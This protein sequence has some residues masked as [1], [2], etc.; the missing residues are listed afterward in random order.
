VYRASD[1]TLTALTYGRGI[2]VTIVPVNGPD[3]SLTWTE[4]GPLDVGGRTR[5]IMVDPN[6]PTGQ[7]VWIGAVFGGLWKTNNID[8]IQSV[9]I[10]SPAFNTSSLNVFPNPVSPVGT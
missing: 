3:Y 6:D 5:A 1:R 4:K 9:G 2:Y 10:S 8:G 7:T